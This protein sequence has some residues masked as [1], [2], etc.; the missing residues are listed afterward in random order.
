MKPI[1]FNTQMVA[2][3]LDGKKTETRRLIQKLDRQRYIDITQRGGYFPMPFL[4]GE[5][6]YV[7]ETWNTCKDGY[8]Y[9]AKTGMIE[10]D[11]GQKW[12]PSIHM[13]KEAARI[14][15]CVKSVSQQWLQDCGNMDAKSEGCNC[16]SQFARVWDSTIKP[17]RDLVKFGWEANPPVWVIQFE[18]I[19]KEQAFEIERSRGNK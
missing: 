10:P 16:C 17:K 11:E 2:A 13:P 5:V 4:K 19:T 12:R 9:K 6:L 15:L 14:F 18:R 8:I 7:R 1:L 3:I